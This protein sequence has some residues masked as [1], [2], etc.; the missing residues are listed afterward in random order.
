[1]IIKKEWKEKKRKIIDIYNRYSQG[2]LNAAA[3]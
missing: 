3:T 1:M 2:T